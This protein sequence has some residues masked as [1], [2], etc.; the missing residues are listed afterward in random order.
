MKKILT[1]VALV[2]AG[3]TASAQHGVGV[4]LGLW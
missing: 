1:L 3:L 2:A 4:H